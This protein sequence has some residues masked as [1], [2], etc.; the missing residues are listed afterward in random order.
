M[1]STW[2][3]Q[4]CNRQ[5]RKVK[6]PEYLCNS[7][8]RH[9]VKINGPAGQRVV[10]N[11]EKN[12]R[13]CVTKTQNKDR[14][15]NPATGRWVNK[16]GRVGQI[17][18]RHYKN[19]PLVQANAKKGKL[20][21]LALK[22]QNVIKPTSPIV[23]LGY[24]FIKKIGSG[25]SSQIYLVSKDSTGEQMVVKKYLDEVDNET[26]LKFSAQVKK[27]SKLKSDHLLQYDS[28]QYNLVTQNEYLIM[29]YFDGHTLTNL[30]IASWTDEVIEQII[31]QLLLGLYDLHV[32]FDLAHEDIKPSNLMISSDGNTIVYMGYG[33]IFDTNS[34]KKSYNLAGG[35]SYYRSPENIA[36]ANDQKMD[37]HKVL[38]KASDIWSLGAVIY[39]VCSG[40]HAFQNA[41]QKSIEDINQTILMGQPNYGLLAPKFQSSPSFMKMLKGMFIT[42]FKKRFDIEKVIELFEKAHT[43]LGW[44]T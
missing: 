29:H 39:Y 31:L 34:W 22:K 11:I 21:L 27:L 30:D 12:P 42:D 4:D 19:V 15:C 44:G 38:L 7:K 10:E 25:V 32:E 28:R 23:P 24:T 2:S 16:N 40:H 8:T 41:S 14:L 1:T 26:D 35:A 9:W 37:Q 5:S 13:K 6:Y 43:E 20:A 36:I 3:F 33:L 17:L 18:Q